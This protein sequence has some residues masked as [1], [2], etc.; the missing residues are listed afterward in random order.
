M[1]WLTN[2]TSHLSLIPVAVQAIQA[3]QAIGHSQE[4]T[5]A[6]VTDIVKLSA[7]V[8]E[9]VPEVHVAAVSTLIESLITQIYG[10]PTAAV[11]TT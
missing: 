4:S 8:G 2:L 9:K 5:L 7:Q 11:P 10:A 1:S 6:K 3:F